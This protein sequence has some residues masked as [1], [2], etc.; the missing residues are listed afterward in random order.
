MTDAPAARPTVGSVLRAFAENVLEPVLEMWIAATVADPDK[1]RADL[2]YLAGR[3]W[4]P[5]TGFRPWS[6]AMQQ[7]VDGRDDIA[8]D[9]TLADALEAALPVGIPDLIRRRPARRSV[10]EAAHAAHDR[11]DYL[12]AIPA[13][14][15]QA[16]GICHDVLATSLFG[17]ERGDG[18]RPATARTIEDRVPTLHTR[19]RGLRGLTNSLLLPL[20]FE[21]SLGGRA[22]REPAGPLNRHAVMHGLASDYGSRAN[23]CRAWAAVLWID[24]L[25][26]LI[27]GLGRPEI[28]AR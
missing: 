12:L 15:A 8:V 13:L 27:E 20:T 7:V 11:G 21:S 4:Y 5:W 17:H 2:V 19:K 14:L 6:L 24:S 16:D 10:L 23:S 22:G 26:A 25:E 3:G 18:R 9:A 1:R 28:S